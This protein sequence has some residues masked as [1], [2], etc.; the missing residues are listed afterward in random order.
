[1]ARLSI[2]ELTTFRWTFEQDL[3]RYREAGISALGVW[4][5]KVSDFGEEK[6]IDLLHESGLHVSNLLWAGGF[7]GSDGRT[8]RDAIDDALDAIE[9][10]GRMN[11]KCVVVYSGGRAGHTHNH[12]RRL[13][14]GALKELLPA[15]RDFSLRLALEPMHEACAAE[16][17]FLTKID[18]ILEL[19]DSVGDDQL[20]MVYDT[21]H[22]GFDPRS[23]ERIGELA[24]R[25]AVVHLG[26]AQ[27]PPAG[28]QNRCQLGE[29]DLPLRETI[30]ALQSA[31]YDGDYDVELIGEAVEDSDY[32]TLLQNSKEFFAAALAS[33]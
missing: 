12:A 4:R 10:A 22:L 14:S 27:G 21:Y 19:F 26:D 9:L 31:G 18:E 11:A 1:M 28:E 25:I 3:A 24:S 32:G 33:C 17:T 15:A 16:F 23:L 2:N 13:L 29:G 20:A 5:Q 8:Y 30:A 6:A 7:T